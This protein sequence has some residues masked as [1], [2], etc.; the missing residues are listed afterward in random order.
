MEGTGRAWERGT[1]SGMWLATLGGGCAGAGLAV[2]WELVLYRT[3]GGYSERR[4]GGKKGS[5]PGNMDLV[6]SWER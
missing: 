6:E 1:S 4:C 5:C 3:K 2:G